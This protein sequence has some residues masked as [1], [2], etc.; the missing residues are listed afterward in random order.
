MR[1]ERPTISVINY[2]Y[3]TA[4]NIMPKNKKG[5]LYSEIEDNAHIKY[6]FMLFH[7]VRKTKIISYYYYY[8]YAP[9]N[10]VFKKKTFL[11]NE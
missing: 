8:Y 6:A 1:F 10:I 4:I 2:Y 11:I 9:I 7:T 3:Y 5:L